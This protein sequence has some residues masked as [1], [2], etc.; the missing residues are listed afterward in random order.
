MSTDQADLARTF[1]TDERHPA[2]LRELAALGDVRRYRKGTILLHEA[3]VGDSLF[4]VL[5]G[6]VKVFCTDA[7]GK[8]IT[9]G[10]FGAGEYFGE[11]ALDGGPR[12]ASVITLQPTACALVTRSTLLAFIAQRPEFALE[13][14]SK[15]IRRLRMA[16]TSARN[17][18]FIDVYGRLTGC[19]QSLATPQ[20]DG[21]RRIEERI[22]HQEIA[23]RAGCSR[24]MVSRILKDLENGGYLRIQERR[25]VLVKKLPLRW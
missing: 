19:L 14:L 7:N 9:F 6:Q 5:A 13:L 3:D 11:M 15:V 16:T 8:E 21:T 20:A 22:T 4:V 10:V 12:S 23:S 17:L 2:L 1:A 24:E 25:I 18:A